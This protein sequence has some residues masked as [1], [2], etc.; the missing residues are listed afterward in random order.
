MQKFIIP[1]LLSFSLVACASFSTQRHPSQET[2]VFLKDSEGKVSEAPA[3]A[4]STGEKDMIHVQPGSDA[5]EQKQVQEMKEAVAAA[6]Q[7]IQDTHGKLPRQPGPVSAEKS[8]GWL[9]NGNT[10]FTKGRFR[11]DGVSAQDRRRLAFEQKPHATIFTCSDSRVSPELI[12]DQKLG[13][14]FVVRTAEIILDKNIQESLEY[15]VTSLG[16]NL[17]VLLGSEGCGDLQAME[18]LSNDLLERSA[19]LRDAITAGEVKI[20]K[21]AYHLEAGNVEFR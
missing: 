15:A 19:I 14:I 2:T 4:T 6:A 5:E 13:E 9:K 8:L 10:R 16:T 7:H 20:V 17:V 3:Q 1:A 18:S 11:N 21:A 12:F